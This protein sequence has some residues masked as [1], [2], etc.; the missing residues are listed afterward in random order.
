MP[1]REL[2][3]LAELTNTPRAGID[4]LAVAD[5][6]NAEPGDTVLTDLFVEIDIELALELA[7]ADPSSAITGAI[8]CLGSIDRA[9]ARCG[10]KGAETQGDGQTEELNES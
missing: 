6:R 10:V 1:W 2:L 5:D 8:G 3:T 9:V 7:H 4:D